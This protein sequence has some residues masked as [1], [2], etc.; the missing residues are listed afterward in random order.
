MQFVG[1]DAQIAHAGIVDGDR[2]RREPEIGDLQFIRGKRDRQRGCIVVM[3]G[4]ECVGLAEVAREPRRLEQHGRP[5]RHRDDEGEP[6]LDRFGARGAD[7]RDQHSRRDGALQRQGFAIHD[8]LPG[9]T[10]LV[11]MIDER[12]ERVNEPT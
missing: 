11:L 7:A 10:F 9:C 12:A 1:D 6:D 5:V 8:L 4:L 3:H 2:Q